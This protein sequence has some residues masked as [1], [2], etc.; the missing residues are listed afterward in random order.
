MAFSIKKWSDTS[1]T[2]SQYVIFR[3]DDF[4]SP[5]MTKHIYS[6]RITYKSTQAHNMNALLNYAL[7]GA[8]SFVTT[9]VPATSVST[10][11]SWDVTVI[12]FTTILACQSFRLKLIHTAGTLNINDIAVE[13]RTIYKRVT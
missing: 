3:D 13:Y 11:S 8:T 7:D 12:T 9:Y 5:A 6:V 10:A 1:A 2:A 4:G